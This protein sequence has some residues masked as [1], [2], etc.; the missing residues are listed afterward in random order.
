M[1]KAG[2]ILIFILLFS[3]AFVI[4]DTNSSTT[5][6]S[7]T[8]LLANQS[9]L[10]KGYTCLEAKVDGKCSTLSIPEISFIIL[11]NPS[12]DITSECKTALLAKKDSAACWPSGSCKI[13]ET[14]L[15]VLALNNLG[16]D[17]DASQE[18]L[19][20]KNKTAEDI[21]WYLE[22]DSN[23]A[24]QCKITYSG[25][26][27][28]VTVG[29][30]KKFS[31]DAGSCL[32]RTPSAFWLQVST[33]CYDKEFA[34][35]CDKDFISTLL[36][37]Y[38]NLPTIYVSSD[39]KSSPA[40]GT[41]SLKINARCFGTSS[42]DY[43][44]SLWASIALLKTGNSIENFLPYLIA[45]S[46]VNKRY[47]P[48]SFIYSVT[49]FDDYGTRLVQEQRLGNYWEAESS[50][51]GKFYD[52]ALGILAL[53]QSSS[54]NVNKAKLWLEFSQDS[55]GCWKSS[56]EIKDTAII[57]W[58]ITD[59]AASSGGTAHTT[60]CSEGNFFC[61]PSS[62]CPSNEQLGNYYCSGLSSVCCKTENLKTC[63]EYSG[64]SCSSGKI[65][66]GN[67]RKASDNA[68]CC[69]GTCED[70]EPEEDPCEAAGNFCKSSCSE[71]QESVQEDCSG[72]LVCCKNKV[73]KDS[74]LWIWLLIIAILIV[75]GII[76]YILRHKIQ[77]FWFNRKNKVKQEPSKPQPPFQPRPGFPPLRGGRPMPAP[78]KQP[79]PSRPVPIRPPIKPSGKQDETFKKLKDMSK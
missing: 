76:I 6:T 20:S 34:V 36:Y 75:L 2:V 68:N 16:E 62:D 52:T 11:S 55:S 9:K 64:V 32:V 19:L 3:L 61:I 72:G 49:G 70:I 22:Q 77:L 38:V 24:T 60:T 48:N 28:S 23:N 56:S 27:Y 31:A 53:K 79:I 37:R 50:A 17:T 26:D 35:S 69:L 29:D 43:E 7:S 46:E 30:N 8:T 1:K 73:A 67:E 41:T 5:S 51:N 71:N 15:A 63:E 65:C 25:S 66:D 59:R 10:D 57:L 54:E 21:V 58:A 74:N 14:A 42:C 13:K 33:S 47:L 78:V 44:G 45:L 4:A 12:D 18:W 40:L 39:T